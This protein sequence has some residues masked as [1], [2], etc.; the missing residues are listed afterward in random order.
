[1]IY[2][3]PFYVEERAVTAPPLALLL[4]ACEVLTQSISM[5]SSAVLMLAL[6]PAVVLPPTVANTGCTKCPLVLDV[7]PWEGGRVTISGVELD[8]SATAWAAAAFFLRSA[9]ASFFSFC[10]CL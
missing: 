6:G 3:D 8:V 7:E 2:A 9:A 5:G 10:S 4:P 1:M